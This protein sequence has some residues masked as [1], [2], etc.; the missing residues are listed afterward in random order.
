MQT[1]VSQQNIEHL[2]KALETASAGLQRQEILRQLVEEEAN[3]K[4]LIAGEPARDAGGN[5]T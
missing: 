3:L 4:R 1:F 5:R 2:K